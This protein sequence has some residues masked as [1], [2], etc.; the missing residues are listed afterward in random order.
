M[1]AGEI[2]IASITLSPFNNKYEKSRRN[3]IKGRYKEKKKSLKLIKY[4]L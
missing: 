3:I 1:P 2:N 4:M